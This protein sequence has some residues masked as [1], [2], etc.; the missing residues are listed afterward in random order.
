MG[1]TKA[2]GGCIPSTAFSVHTRHGHG[3]YALFGVEPKFDLSSADSPATIGIPARFGIGFDNFYGS[4]TGTATY[5]SIGLAYAQPVSIG[6]GHLSLRAQIQALIRDNA[7]C[8]LGEADA[9]HGT[10]VPLAT[11]GATVSF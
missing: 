11:L 2:S 9:E 3:A 4:G 1:R 8:A 6:A 7:V 10:V 5:G